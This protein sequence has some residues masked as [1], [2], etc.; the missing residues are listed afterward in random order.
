MGL[1]ETKEELEWRKRAFE[2]KQKIKE[3][4][5]MQFTA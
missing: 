3:Y 5:L 1:E 4:I 2:F